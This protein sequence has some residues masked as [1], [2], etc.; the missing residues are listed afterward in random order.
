MIIVGLT[1]SIGMGKSTTAALFAEAGL[2]VHSA[3]EAVH[4]LYS[5]EAVPAIEAAFPGTVREGSVD[6]ALLSERVVGNKAAMERLE[7]IVHPLV[8][9][10]ER[11][12]IQGSEKAGA[13]AAILDIPLLFETGAQARCD[14]VVVVSAPFAVQTERVLA[15]TGMS[16]EK[17]Q[18]ILAKQMPD[19]EKRARADFVVDSSTGIEDARRQVAA[20]LEKILK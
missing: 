19:A 3:D 2:P 12:F 1:G 17:F 13:P 7:A 10:A 16:A 4:A 18:A 6:R 14:L 11:D 9:A 15:R 8:H 5:G 20:I